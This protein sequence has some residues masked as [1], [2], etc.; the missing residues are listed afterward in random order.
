MALGF[1]EEDIAELLLLDFV[2][3]VDDDADEE[4]E[5]ELRADDHVADEEE[6]GVDLVVLLGLLVHTHRVH[7][8]P[9]HRQPALSRHHL[10]QSHHGRQDVVKV[11]SCVFPASAQV[12][13]V[14]LLLHTQQ[15]LFR[16]A[17][18]RVESALV[19]VYSHYRKNHQEKQANHQHVCHRWDRRD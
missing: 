18:A 16:K 5:D 13:A 9:H 11:R 10:E 14:L 3:V 7:A 15:Q 12:Q 8:R 19:E 2:E 1:G 4:V 6:R 17:L